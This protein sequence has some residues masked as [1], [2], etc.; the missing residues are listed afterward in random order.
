MNS[1]PKAI[2]IAIVLNGQEFVCLPVTL[3]FSLEG[4]PPLDLVLYGATPGTSQALQVYPIKDLR[5]DEF[6]LILDGQ[7]LTA[8]LPDFSPE[9]LSQLISGPLA[10]FLK[11]LICQLQELRQKQEINAG[12][13]KSATDGI[14]TINEDHV[15]I[16]YNEGAEKM[17][18]YSRGEALGQDLNIL[19]PPPYKEVHRGFVRRYVA[20]REARVIG[21]HV[22]LKA[23]RRDGSEFPMSISFSVAEI[24][25]NLYFTGVIRD[26]TEYQEMQDRLL[27]S[28][29]LAAV[30][31]TVTHIAHEIKNPLLIIGGFARQL[32]KIP[33]LDDKSRQKLNI[34]AEEVSNLEAMVAEM[35]DFVRLP[36]AVKSQGRLEE[37][38][39]EALELFRDT[40]TENHIKSK[41][42]EDGPLPPLDFD[43]KQLRQVLINLFKNALE[44]MPRGG[45]IAIST[46]VSGQNAEIV[47]ADTGEGMD[48]EVAANIF[49]PYFTTKAQGT[50]LGLA[51]CQ[52]IIRGHGG[53]ISVKSTPG[54]GTAFTIQL[55]LAP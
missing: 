37:A 29:R 13:I 1:G 20:T 4:Y 44:A 16:G 34:I 36:P 48:P 11:G 38:I 31:N 47:L 30:G 39:S 40:F 5:P 6:D 19:I 50:G 2:R 43:P 49:Q 26:I 51:I 55:P 28:E 33:G 22:R 53:S 54:K 7:S 41:R 8:G 14:V 46:R 35:R 10:N 27:Q 25:D 17:F 18:G 32:I 45:E 21:K 42:V 52:S 23:Q 9:R 15:I 3:P 24:R 12:I